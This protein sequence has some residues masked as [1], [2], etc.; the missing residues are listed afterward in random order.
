MVEF[1]AL[2]FPTFMTLEI[3][4]KRKKLEFKELI[5]KY[6]LYNLAVNGIAFLI[7]YLIKGRILILFSQSID[8]VGFAIK[9]FILALVVATFIPFMEEYCKKN[10]K[11]KIR[12]RRDKK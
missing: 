11:F 8:S 10:V 2:F 6:P 9:Y 5:F 1:I 12:I 3:I 7:L 4:K